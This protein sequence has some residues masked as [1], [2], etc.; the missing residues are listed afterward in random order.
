MVHSCGFQLMLGAD[1]A[2]AQRSAKAV[3]RSAYSVVSPCGLGFS[4][5]GGGVPKIRVIEGSGPTGRKQEARP[6][7]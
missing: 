4:Q 2:K 3:D 1:S 6:E 5:H 7:W